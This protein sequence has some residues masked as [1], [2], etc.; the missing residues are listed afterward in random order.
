MKEELKIITTKQAKLVLGTPMR[1]THRYMHDVR[2][3]FEKEPQQPVTRQEF[4]H[5]FNFSMEHLLKALN[6]K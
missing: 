1:T 6:V 2:N 5:Y 3:Y 4:C